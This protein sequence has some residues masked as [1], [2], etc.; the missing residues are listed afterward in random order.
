[1]KDKPINEIRI[2]E[3]LPA[4]SYD[5]SLTSTK[6]PTIPR[7]VNKA[8]LD[9]F[10][11]KEE[12]TVQP[13]ENKEY[14][15]PPVLR[16]GDQLL[17]L[18]VGDLVPE[19]AAV[20]T[21][22]SV[23][24]VI[25]AEGLQRGVEDQE[26]EETLST[27]TDLLH[28]NGS[29]FNESFVNELNNDTLLLKTENDTDDLF[30]D[31]QTDILRSSTT[32]FYG[33]VT[34]NPSVLSSSYDLNSTDD[35]MESSTPSV[36]NNSEKSPELVMDEE[37]QS[38]PIEHL[39]E[40]NPEYPPIPE[41]IMILSMTE[42]PAELGFSEID[43][44]G[45]NPAQDDNKDDQKIKIVKRPVMP[46]PPISKQNKHIPSDKE[47]KIILEVLHAAN[48]KTNSSSTPSTLI[49][50]EW[51]KTTPI[52]IETSSRRLNSPLIDL[53]LA[54]P[55]SILNADNENTESSEE[56]NRE[57]IFVSNDT[58]NANFSKNIENETEN[59][60]NEIVFSVS[61]SFLDINNEYTT[62][63]ST[64]ESFP[65]ISFE[66]LNDTQI[67]L[68]DMI[69]LPENDRNEP[70]MIIELEM[71]S[72]ETNIADKLDV[73]NEYATIEN[74]QEFTDDTITNLI[75]S[76]EK[77][78]VKL[79]PTTE[80]Q[81]NNENKSWNLSKDTEVISNFNPQSNPEFYESPSIKQ[82]KTPVSDLK[83]NER[84]KSKKQ[85]NILADLISLVGDVASIGTHDV[86]VSSVH[87]SLEFEKYT[88]DPN[89]PQTEKT[90]PL[91]QIS[92]SIPDIATPIP[93]VTV[94][95]AKVELSEYH[96]GDFHIPETTTEHEKIEF[97]TKK[98]IIDKDSDERNKWKSTDHILHEIEIIPKL[99]NNI[100]NKK[101]QSLEKIIKNNE[102]SSNVIFKEKS[103]AKEVNKVNK[104]STSGSSNSQATTKK[105]ASSSKPQRTTAFPISTILTEPTTRKSVSTK[106]KPVSTSTG[107][108]T[109]LIST[110]GRS[111]IQTSNSTGTQISEVPTSTA[112]VTTKPKST[113]K[114]K[115][116]PTKLSVST[117]AA[118][119]D[120]P[121]TTAAPTTTTSTTTTP[122][123]STTTTATTTTASPSTTTV[124]STTTSSPTPITSTTAATPSTTTST[125][126]P[127]TTTSTPSTTTLSTTTSTTTAAP[128][129]TTTTAAPS[130]TTSTTRAPST[131]SSTTTTTTTTESPSLEFE[132]EDDISSESQITE[133]DAET[134]KR[135][136]D[137]SYVHTLG[138]QKET[139]L[140]NILK[141][142]V[143]KQYR[144]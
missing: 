108:K 55:D 34:L 9:D 105:V 107:N 37:Q 23:F 102:N 56:D 40:H 136:T 72:N 44:S 50:E 84:N 16:I 104:S 24:T 59:S 67:L 109:G 134:S 4:T 86:E 57:Y 94:N 124:P 93:E 20:N 36:E 96:P 74:V 101:N 98:I 140:M 49:P 19:N 137:D 48:N 71:V 41:D 7:E 111:S 144:Q 13:E 3:I 35:L 76:T 12:V 46:L 45:V 89:K 60:K 47:S 39:P 33:G 127:S 69:I 129:I 141:D 17:F 14:Q 66:S 68:E 5:S 73:L 83:L 28:L 87:N 125:A 77:S 106:L 132:A 31:A 54:L 70:E 88:V 135:E 133:G 8:I 99:E 80:V 112:R 81:E 11:I 117:T 27:K 42:E 79:T 113:T 75:V 18:N 22:S 51:L 10:I 25:G 97:T 85:G 115:I 118:T 128:S 53:N 61:E 58:L 95:H 91:L 138:E 52:P 82:K 131:T 6:S 26:E 119:T 123:P 116:K 103:P 21:P 15:T 43:F 130:T 2:K 62:S 30:T 29:S 63:A 100:N 122:I 78:I 38:I 143:E 142:F 65:V 1:M 110:G 139:S 126:F 114:P 120:A 92:T 121:S 32:D 90:P 64:T